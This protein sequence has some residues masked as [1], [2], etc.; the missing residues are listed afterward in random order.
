VLD[1]LLTAVED[2]T[3]RKTTTVILAGY[4]DEIEKLLTYNIG[5]ASRFSVSLKFPDYSEQQ[6]RSIFI[7]MTKARGFRLEKMM[8]SSSTDIASVIAHRLAQG[9]GSNVATADRARADSGQQHQ[10]LSR[11]HVH[12]FE[13]IHVHR[14]MSMCRQSVNILAHYMHSYM[15]A[16][17]PKYMCMC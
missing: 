4:S 5:F 14:Y 7:S 11:S 16:R 8:R 3:I 13:C 6:L 15:H 2:D 17:T 10:L 1:C 9:A 12:M